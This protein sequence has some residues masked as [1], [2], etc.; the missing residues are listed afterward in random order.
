MDQVTWKIITDPFTRKSELLTGGVDILPFVIPE[1]VDEID[2]APN[3]RIESTI[4]S[5]YLFIGLPVREPP[6][7]NIRVRKALNYAVKRMN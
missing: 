6:Y 7:N 4:S 3:V 2:T 5:R 1:W